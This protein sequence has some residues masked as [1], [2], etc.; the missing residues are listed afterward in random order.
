MLWDVWEF[1]E[2]LILFGQVGCFFV[3]SNRDVTFIFYFLLELFFPNPKA[4]QLIYE[5]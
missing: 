1:G 2:L 3:L 5:P 4:R